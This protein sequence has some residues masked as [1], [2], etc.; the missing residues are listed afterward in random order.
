MDKNRKSVKIKK[1]EVSMGKKM[2]KRNIL[3]LTVT[4]IIGVNGCQIN[5]KSKL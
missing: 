3:L 1:L 4:I 5:K 2:K